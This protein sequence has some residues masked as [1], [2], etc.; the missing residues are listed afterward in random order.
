MTKTD[1]L[2]CFK[3]D[4]IC[5]AVAPKK[6]V[7]RTNQVVSLVY[8]KEIDKLDQKKKLKIDPHT[9]TLYS[10][11]TNNLCCIM[12]RKANGIHK[13]YSFANLKSFL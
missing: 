10:K 5:H 2:K 13:F 9:Q 8:P 7:G 11:N 4:N 3:Q 12:Y 6:N 1:I